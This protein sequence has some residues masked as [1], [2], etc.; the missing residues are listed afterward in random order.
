MAKISSSQT[1]FS[2]TQIWVWWTRLKQQ[3]KPQTANEKKIVSVIFGS[4]LSY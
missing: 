3:S 4:S 2:V 1:L